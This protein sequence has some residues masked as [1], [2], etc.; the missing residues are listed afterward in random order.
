M[1]AWFTVLRLASAAVLAFLSAQ[2]LAC[3]TESGSDGKTPPGT[4]P[5]PGEIK[6]PPPDPK[7]GREVPADWEA[8]LKETITEVDGRTGLGPD[9]KVDTKKLEADALTLLRTGGANADEGF[10]LAVRKVLHSYPVGHLQI[11]PLDFKK[12]GTPDLPSQATS[13]VDACTQP[14]DDHAVVTVVGA[15]N[16]LKLAPGDE[17]V[18]VDGKKGQAMLDA[19][20][21]HP[22]CGT[23]SPG[24]ANRRALSATSL[25]A[26]IHVGSTITVKHR[27]GAIEVKTVDKL[28]KA[29][30][31]SDPFGR[32]ATTAAT[33]TMRPDGA[34]VLRIPS[35]Y[36]R[37]FD[38]KDPQ[39]SIDRFTN[40]IK[41]EF[42]KVKN[43]KELIIDV[44]AN[45]GGATLVGL[46]IAG[47][48]PGAK[49]M[50]IAHCQ[51]RVPYE[52][53][54]TSDFDYDLTP[55]THFAYTG[56]VAVL[57]DGLSFSATD[58][59]IRTMRIATN[60]IV[61]GR[62]QAAAYGGSTGELKIEKGPGLYVVPDPWRCTEPG[63]KPLEG[64]S[65][66][67]DFE[68]DLAP[69]DLD[70]GLDSD[71]E[72]ALGILRKP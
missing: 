52:T 66:K 49:A 5:P 19:T 24:A 22:M 27:N 67:L 15:S 18:E 1:Q 62:P 39:G 31:C 60:A 43:A 8:A 35:F 7:P 38:E 14:F 16:P 33:A 37:D 53:T 2:V 36:P 50:P 56:K 21:E 42:D 28:G 11:Y 57:S 25:L 17:I 20:F 41:A 58:Y 61:G 26:T 9:L 54:Y 34:A 23:A 32:V 59:F 13:F 68:Q 29:K 47:G 69:A 45:G 12:C 30:S 70:K 64:Q 55:S 10:R 72:V 71:V 4:E 46:A 44:R 3:T 40:A 6:N 63:G 51:E 65:V 48:M